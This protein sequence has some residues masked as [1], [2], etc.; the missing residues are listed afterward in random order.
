M[1]NVPL[2]QRPKIVIKIKSSKPYI[3]NYYRRVD[4]INPPY[5]LNIF[6]L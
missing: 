2:R 1:N 4:K 3:H 6:Y 5:A